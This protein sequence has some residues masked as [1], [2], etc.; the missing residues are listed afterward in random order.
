MLTQTEGRPS[1][2]ELAVR[3]ANEAPS[4]MGDTNS[5]RPSD[6]YIF[7]NEYRC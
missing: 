7:L 5:P 6:A 4:T 1:D 2:S 3:K